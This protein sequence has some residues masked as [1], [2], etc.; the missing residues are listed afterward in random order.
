ML[1]EFD[2]DFGDVPV[3]TFDTPDRRRMA[4]GAL[5]ARPA[6]NNLTEALEDAGV[7]DAAKV[8]QLSLERASTVFPND[9]DKASKVAFIFAFTFDFDDPEKA[10]K[11][12]YQLLN[13]GLSSEK[14][15][16][17]N[18]VR[19]FLWGLLEG[20]RLEAPVPHEHLYRA[21]RTKVE[22][23]PGQVWSWP[24]FSSCTVAQDAAM[25]FLNHEQEQATGTMINIVGASGFHIDK[26]SFISSEKEV[27]LEPGLSFVVRSIIPGPTNIVEVEYMKDSQRMLI[28]EIP[29][30][31][32][33]AEKAES[34]AGAAGKAETKIEAG[35]RYCSSKKYKKA[36]DAFKDALKEDSAVMAAINIG[37]LHILGLGVEKDV[38]AGLKMWSKAAKEIKDGKDGKGDK[39]D[40]DGRDGRDTKEPRDWRKDPCIFSVIS[41]DVLD[42]HGYPIG[43]KEGKILAALIELG[44]VPPSLILYDTS[45]TS[46]QLTLIS[47]AIKA[48]STVT[49]L[50]VSFNAMDTGCANT[51]LENLKEYTQLKSLNI[52]SSSLDDEVSDSLVGFIA[53]C[54]LETL[55]ISDN[56][57]SDKTMSDVF[58]EL[59]SNSTITYLSVSGN[60]CGT[61]ALKD[62]GKILSTNTTIKTLNLCS[63]KISSDVPDEFLDGLKEMKSLTE[64]NLGDNKIEDGGMTQIA[65]SLTGNESLEVINLCSNQLTCACME[66]V[67][68]FLSGSSIKVLNLSL[69]NLGDVGAK[70]LVTGIRDCKHIKE[71]YLQ[72]IG[73]G[74]AG[75]DA[76]SE[77]PK[78]KK[79]VKSFSYW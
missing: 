3:L 31:G 5:K 65:I 47:T 48:S 27:L 79:K 72:S 2:I 55:D 52:S 53:Q 40:K 24:A 25:R 71:I 58:G 61:S 59:E 28:D 38:Q 74:T 50:D 36:M 49:S 16:D 18:S 63:C 73:I 8:A 69:N 60:E 23:S 12:P 7:P 15:M 10:G 14:T 17:V 30:A 67:S 32:E 19:K 4:D 42:L 75:R 51:F 13:R 21:L 6:N 22:L 76:L 33:V 39:G 1:C 64:L 54:E 11:N 57:L 68:K 41:P 9:P 43:K 62:L 45:L 35:V 37:Y 44:F 29:Q 56:D 46:E 34:P 78:T 77:I 66:A 20:L 26:Y 70:T